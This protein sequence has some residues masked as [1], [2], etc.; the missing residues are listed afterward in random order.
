MTCTSQK[1]ASMFVVFVRGLNALDRP[2]IICTREKFS[3]P[4]VCLPAHKASSKKDLH[5]LVLND[6]PPISNTL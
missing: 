4:L 2:S 1:Q 5:E 6:L 3:K